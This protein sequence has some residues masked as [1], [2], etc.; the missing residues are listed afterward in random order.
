[1]V[2]FETM[3]S[4]QVPVCEKYD[5]ICLFVTCSKSNMQSFFLLIYLTCHTSQFMTLV[6][7]LY[8]IWFTQNS[9]FIDIQFFYLQFP[10]KCKNKFYKT[11]FSLFTTT[12]VIFINDTNT[13]KGR[14]GQSTLKKCLVQS[15]KTCLRVD[16]S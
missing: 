6:L 11:Q 3:S 8:H 2:P 9:S 4:K 10:W 13:I 1:M 15:R 16:P 12:V 7:A 14:R 5:L